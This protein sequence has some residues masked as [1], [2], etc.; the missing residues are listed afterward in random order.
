MPS[1]GDQVVE[2]Q[3]HTAGD[4]VSL[5]LPAAVGGNVALTYSLA[6]ELPA[7]LE[8]DGETRTISGTPPSDGCARM[9][10]MPRA[11]R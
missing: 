1:F 11:M 6:G 8:F 5:L 9:R 4:G 10:C 2:D 7:G 3:M